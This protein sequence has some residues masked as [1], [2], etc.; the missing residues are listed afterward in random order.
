MRA[1]SRTHQI[2]T[3][4]KSYS[5]LF[6]I[7]NYE[8]HHRNKVGLKIDTEVSNH[9][10]AGMHLQSVL[11]SQRS[12]EPSGN[13]GL[14]GSPSVNIHVKGKFYTSTFGLRNKYKKVLIKNPNKLRGKLIL[15]VD[16]QASLIKES[17]AGMKK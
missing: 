15:R 5:N 7:L 3:A 16:N 11:K 13:Y 10:I 8:R 1:L 6:L 2:S 17:R 9:G 4:K 12:T 14:F